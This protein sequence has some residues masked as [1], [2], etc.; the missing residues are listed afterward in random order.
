MPAKKPAKK[1]AAPKLLV[2][3]HDFSARGPFK[4]NGRG[5]YISKGHFVKANSKLAKAFPKAFVTPEDYA[6]Q[7][8]PVTSVVK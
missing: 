5:V 2:A 6:Q 7:Q 3:K 1:K 4:V 8:A